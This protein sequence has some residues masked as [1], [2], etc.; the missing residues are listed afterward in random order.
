[1]LE[2]SSRGSQIGGHLAHA[3]PKSGDIRGPCAA[4]IGGH[5]PHARPDLGTFG[6]PGRESGDIGPKRLGKTQK[7]LVET[8][9]LFSIANAPN[10]AKTGT[11]G[12]TRRRNG[13][14]GPCVGPKNADIW[15]RRP[16]VQTRTPRAVPSA[17]ATRTPRRICLK[18]QQLCCFYARY[19]AMCTIAIQYATNMIN[20][21]HF[22][23]SQQYVHIHSN[24]YIYQVV[25]QQYVLMS[26][27]FSAICTYTHKYI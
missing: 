26:S 25:S 12:P 14:I 16:D 21:I 1:M 11:S 10:N 22:D 15:P 23:G 3:R 17:P 5:L 19:I 9:P 24:M 27:R 2:I 7:Q 13:D 18:N 8:H 6:P 4:Q 20:A